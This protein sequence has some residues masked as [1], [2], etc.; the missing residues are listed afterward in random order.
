MMAIVIASPIMVLRAGLPTISKKEK[1]LEKKSK[2]L[3]KIV[4]VM[5][6]GIKRS[7]PCI[8]YDTNFFT[9]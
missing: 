2:S 3:N 5:I 9:L 8:K 4:R 1:M 6:T 7:K